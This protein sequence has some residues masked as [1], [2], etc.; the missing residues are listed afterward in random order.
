MIPVYVVAEG[1]GHGACCKSPVRIKTA[2]TREC[3]ASIA[4]ASR[5][6]RRFSSRASSLE[7][8]IV[9][10]F[11]RAK[12]V[13]RLVIREGCHS[14][15]FIQLAWRILP[16]SGKSRTNGKGTNQKSPDLAGPIAVHAAPTPRRVAASVALPN[17]N[18]VGSD[19]RRACR[20]AN[21]VLL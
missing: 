11:S 5:L 12:F 16:P 20:C 13:K 7:R 8:H 19:A 1:S 9:L 15:H 2:V 3:G 6:E 14:R 10:V 17:P 18:A 21:L 4:S